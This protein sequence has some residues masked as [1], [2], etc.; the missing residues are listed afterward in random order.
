VSWYRVWFFYNNLQEIHWLIRAFLLPHWSGL[1]PIP[2]NIYEHPKHRTTTLISQSVIQCSLSLI[3]SVS[4]KEPSAFW[5]LISEGRG[6]QPQLRLFGLDR[7][8]RSLFCRNRWG[9]S[10]PSDRFSSIRGDDQMIWRVLQ[11]TDVEYQ[12]IWR[13]KIPPKIEFHSPSR[14]PSSACIRTPLNW[15][16]APWWASSVPRI[17]NYLQCYFEHEVENRWDFIG[18]PQGL[19]WFAGEKHCS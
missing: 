7:R 11:C 14:S 18:F 4:T 12:T 9:R 6:T 10:M 19:L 5:C 13:L 1:P 2:T 8:E 16:P 15:E 3:T 17:P